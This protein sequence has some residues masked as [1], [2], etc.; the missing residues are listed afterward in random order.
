MRRKRKQ[1]IVIL[2]LLVVLSFLLLLSDTLD[3][4]KDKGIYNISI[5][6]TGKNSEGLMIMKQGIDQASSE[7]NVNVSFV[8]LSEDN[9]YIE[10]TELIAR[11]IKNRADAIIISPVD[12]DKMAEPIENAMKNIPVI[13]IE[14]TVKSEHVLPSISCNNYKLGISLAEEMVSNGK[15]KS[16]IAIIK[17]NLECSSIKERY[18]GFMSV[19]DK[20]ENNYILWEEVDDKQVTHNNEAKK[21]L[22]ENNVDAVVTFDSDMLEGVAQ[23]KRDLSSINKDKAYIEIYGTGSTSRIISFLEDKV[24]SATA[25]Q[26]EFNIGY[27]AVK[28]AIYKING[29]NI[30]NSTISSTVINTKNMYSEENQKLLFPFVR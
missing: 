26:N 28:T 6:T 21:L 23:A 4:E 10:Q 27:L 18:D 7:M 29:K 13:L 2:L 3:H 25:I 5:I 20:T 8:T 15:I 19:M 17:N 1:T 12:Y 24:I 14:S 9:N 16:N 30:N 11:E 22:E